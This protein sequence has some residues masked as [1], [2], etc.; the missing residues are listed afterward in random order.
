M[1]E[2]LV[3]SQ[4]K[5]VENADII[6]PVEIEGQI[7]QIY[8]LVRPGV[9]EF[10]KRMS[11]H[12]EMVVFTA[13]LSKYAEPLC[14]QLDPEG[15]C[16]YKLF[17]EHCT[18]YN[19]AFVKDLTRLGRPMTDVIIVDNSPIAFMFQPE[20]AIPCISWYDDMEDNELARIANLLEKL[21]YEED[22]RKIIRKVFKNNQFDDRAEQLYLH[23]TKR[24][25]S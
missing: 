16:S 15:F 3:H 21:A 12:F 6:L 22:V 7:C 5:P 18:F 17:R 25:H 9:T 1:D 11:K 24:D 20:N 23:S 4:F 19:N 13:S 10:L 8:I 2:T 14:A